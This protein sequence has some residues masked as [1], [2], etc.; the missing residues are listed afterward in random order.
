MNLKKLLFVVMLAGAAL[1]PTFSF[2]ASTMVY[3]GRPS[4]GGCSGTGICS[5]GSQVTGVSTEF[6]YVA[7]N[8]SG[9]VLTL[10]FN[11]TN[12]QKAG[13]TP[14]RSGNTYTFTDGYSFSDAD[15]TLCGVPKG[16]KIP[17]GYVAT[18]NPAT[19][20]GSCSLVI[21]QKN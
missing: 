15:A 8:N 13:F 19:N 2:G 17:A 10:T 1:A 3:Y 11:F 14:D 16:Y 9:S 5:L 6:S 18:Y 7:N 4:G 21:T 12:G 20:G